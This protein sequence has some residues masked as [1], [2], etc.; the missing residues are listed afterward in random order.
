MTTEFQFGM[1]SCLVDPG[2]LPYRDTCT[3]CTSRGND[4]FFFVI[5]YLCVLCAF[6]V[7]FL[8]SLRPLRLCGDI[9]LPLM[10]G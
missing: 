9:N 3:S 1:D 6:A 5:I 10:T 8:F 4:V 2:N 7:S